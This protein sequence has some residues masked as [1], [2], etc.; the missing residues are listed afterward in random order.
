MLLRI[1]IDFFTYYSLCMGNEF[2]KKALAVIPSRGACSDGGTW[3]R[4]LIRDIYGA[5]FANWRETNLGGG[6]DK[7]G[8]G[9]SK[10]GGT[11]G[12][13]S[14]AGG[15]VTNLRATFISSSPHECWQ[16]KC[17]EMLLCT[18]EPERAAKA[19]GLG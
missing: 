15:G 9:L 14:L 7:E 18:C 17:A 10:D 12:G 2:V 4:W 6:P 11:K 13:M 19:V 1:K 8:G 3:V 5:I 16:V